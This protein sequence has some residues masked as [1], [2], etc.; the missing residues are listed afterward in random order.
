VATRKTNLNVSTA[1]INL[2]L[3][4]SQTNKK[5]YHWF[6]KVKV[7]CNPQQPAELHFVEGW[8]ERIKLNTNIA[9]NFEQLTPLQQA[10]IYAE[11]GIWH[12]TLT[13]LAELRLNNQSSNKSNLTINWT[14]LLRSVDLEN[15]ADYPLVDCCKP[16]KKKGY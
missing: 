16:V 15:L 1:S 8:I 12:N 9:D 6:F 11:N 5:V 10:V 7:R 4:A 14:N 3:E 13:T 2:P